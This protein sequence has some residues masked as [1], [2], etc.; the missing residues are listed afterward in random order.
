MRGDP[1]RLCEEPSTQSF[2]SREVSERRLVLGVCDEDS[3]L[4]TPILN[5]AE[6]PRPSK[7]SLSLL[8]RVSL[9]QSSISSPYDF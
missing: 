5:L 9:G 7:S 8:A 2:L 4:S 6:H 3:M 1:P